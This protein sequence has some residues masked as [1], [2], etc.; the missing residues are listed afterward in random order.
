M[1]K[2]DLSWSRHRLI[3]EVEGEPFHLDVGEDTRKEACWEA[4]G[5]TVGRISSDD[6]YERPQRLL[7][8]APV[9]NV[10]Q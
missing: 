4:A 6:V 5:W 7:R 3:I 1:K 2:R 8:L 10:P 9:P